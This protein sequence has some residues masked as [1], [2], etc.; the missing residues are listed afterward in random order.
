MM[1]A[2]AE[3]GVIKLMGIH[4]DKSKT[5]PNCMSNGNKIP[6]VSQ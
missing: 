3:A 5:Q 2:E 1:D 4:M 6:L